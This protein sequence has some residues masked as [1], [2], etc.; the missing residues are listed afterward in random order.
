MKC[1][2]KYYVIM[3]YSINYV[4]SI[5]APGEIFSFANWIIPYTI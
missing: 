1:Q 5:F 4:Y 3:L 2:M